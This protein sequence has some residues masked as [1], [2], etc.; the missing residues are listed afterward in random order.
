M[1]RDGIQGL[2][3]CESSTLDEEERRANWVE[4]WDWAWQCLEFG[5]ER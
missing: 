1:T 5:L 3:L 2:G 4:T